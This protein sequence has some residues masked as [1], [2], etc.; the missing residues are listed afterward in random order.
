MEKILP[1]EIIEFIFQF[2]GTISQI[3]CL[4]INHWFYNNLRIVNL[5]RWRSEGFSK[6]ALAKLSD[7]TI[8]LYPQCQRLWVSENPNITNLIGLA[9]L[10]ILYA[11]ND[12]G[13]NQNAILGLLRL[14]ELNISGNSKICD[15]N[16]L[17]TGRPP[18]TPLFVR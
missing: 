8:L 7:K 5:S 6:M 13:I 12:C 14:T 18:L 4:S 2:C 9:N 10:T 16:H 15:L 1:P 3:R 17:T 11:E